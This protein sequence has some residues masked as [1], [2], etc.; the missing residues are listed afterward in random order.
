[1]NEL[2]DV[3]ARTGEEPEV[4]QLLREFE[5]ATARDGQLST[6]KALAE[7]TRYALWDYQ[8]EEGKKKDRDGAPAFPWNNASDTRIRLA[9]E[10]QNELVADLETGFAHAQFGA[11]SIEMEDMLPAQAVAKGLQWARSSGL[12]NVAA[13][14]ELCAQW[15]M[16]YGFAVVQTTWQRRIARRYESLTMEE[17]TGMAQAMAQQ[18]QQQGVQP[19]GDGGNVV[20]MLLQFVPDPSKEEEAIGIVQ[21]L[22]PMFCHQQ[23]PGIFMEEIGEL[24]KA[25][26][27]KVVRELRTNGSTRMACPYVA[28]NNPQVVTLKPG[29]DVFFPV[30]TV[31]M[32]TARWVARL[33]W[34]PE[35]DV[36]AKVLTEG[37][38]EGW[39]EKV[40]ASQP[41]G[42]GVLGVGLGLS[43][44]QG[45]LQHTADGTNYRDRR[46][47]HPIL[48]IYRRAVD[49]EGVEGIWCTVVSP[50]IHEQ[51]A[52]GTQPYAKN[53]LLNYAHGEFPFKVYRRERP[54]RKIMESRGVPEIVLTWQNEKKAA[55]D[56][57]FDRNSLITV[58]PIKVPERTKGKVYRLAPAATIRCARPDEVEWMQPPPGNIVEGLQVTAAVEMDVARYFGTKREGVDPTLTATMQQARV[59][60]FL[61]TWMEVFGQVLALM[62]QFLSDEDWQRIAGAAAPTRDWE[63]IQRRYSYRLKFKMMDLSADFMETKLKLVGQI[64]PMDTG[65]VIDRTKLVQASLAWIDAQMA[66]AV[67]SSDAPASQKIFN[68]VQDDLVKMLAGMEPAYTES[69]PTA[70][71]QLEYAQQIMQT[72]PKLQQALK[73]DPDFQKLAEKWAKNRTFSVQE[74]QNAVTGRIGVDPT[75]GK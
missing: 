40:I 14:A 56:G 26:A 72:N 29:E 5:L 67:V 25:D 52:T 64:L 59:D 38:D 71:R 70:K 24:S 7:A 60:K 35:V 42:D 63:T 19:S 44:T 28:A 34:L 69:D 20:G 15:G 31:D 8:N 47:L 11:D 4:W 30:E 50:H 27:R 58:P 22:W 61:N 68:Q 37:W 54:E 32:D 12:R 62:E 41:K 10:V 46:N 17:L 57:M 3:L 74:Q 48:W 16:A 21:M 1:M 2:G 18:Q 33:D 6:R 65:G 23:S 55:R 53:E 73:S 13:E 51:S 75:A 45:T 43:A 36:R 39:V 49:A 66:Q 9:D